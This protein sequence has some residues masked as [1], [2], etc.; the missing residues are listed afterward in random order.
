[1]KTKTA[2][3][4]IS[5]IVLIVTLMLVT[6]GA[7]Y[8]AIALVIGAVL[9]GHRE[10]WS[11]LT[12]KKMPPFDERIQ[13]SVNKAVR[14]GFV[15]LVF[16][17]V[18]LMLPFKEIFIGEFNLSQILAGLIIS[19]GVVYVFSYFYY[20]KSRPNLGRKGLKVLQAFIITAGASIPGFILGAYLHNAVS[21]LFNVEEPVF[22]IIAVIG[23]PAALATGLLGSFTVFL[24]GLIKK[25]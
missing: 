8:V 9:F 12:K 10:L 23:A 5:I 6:A 22:F 4:T 24:K 1:M 2:F 7:F 17:L 11:L 25:A 21:Y 18:F 19:G 20:E 15:F 14:N 3:L 13:E 16:M